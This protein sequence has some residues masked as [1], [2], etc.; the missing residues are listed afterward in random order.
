MNFLKAFFKSRYKNLI[1]SLSQ[2]NSLLFLFF[3]RHVYKP[4]KKS[5]AEF[6]DAYSRAKCEVTVVQIGANDGFNHDPIHKFIKRD[7][8]KG[9][10]VEPQTDVFNK[11][12]EPLH[13]N[14]PGINTVNAAIDRKCGIKTLYTIAF[15]DKRWA[16]GLSSFKKEVLLE[17]FESGYIKACAEREGIELP[18]SMEEA[19]GEVEVPVISPRKLLEEYNL[20]NIDWLQVDT[21]GFDYEI[22]KMFQLEKLQPEVVVFENSHLSQK[23]RK[24]AN[25]YLEKCGYGYY[26]YGS[27]TLAVNESLLSKLPLLPIPLN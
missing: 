7:G 17:A 25:Q 26:D 24:S 13:E 11:Y 27:N 23:D 4:K 12:L 21:E 2:H 22:L 15:T 19:I 1:F 18:E 10:L 8:W 14:S 20:K 16:T 9:V 3:Y 5:L 6:A